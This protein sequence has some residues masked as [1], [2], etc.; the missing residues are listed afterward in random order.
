MSKIGFIKF[1]YNS[2][3]KD[4]VKSTSYNTDGTTNVKITLNDMKQLL[5]SNI[6]VINELLNVS[7]Q[8]IDIEYT[9]YD[10]IAM[11]TDSQK[12][13]DDLTEKNI[14]TTIILDDYNSNSDSEFDENILFRLDETLETDTQ[15]FQAITN[16]TRQQNIPI[17]E[18]ENEPNYSS[19]DDEYSSSQETLLNC[20]KSVY[21]IINKYEK[22]QTNHDSCD[23]NHHDLY[24]ETSIDSID[25]T[26][27]D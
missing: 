19:S 5:E 23:L 21:S 25:S 2:P 17:L 7:D 14:V 9:G 3:Q 6:N 16:I 13:I 1:T 4:I 18:P 15:R 24:D 26:S 20:E 27:L 8:I 22:I 12:V 10:I 11:I